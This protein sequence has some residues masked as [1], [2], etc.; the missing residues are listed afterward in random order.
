M[1]ASTI[2]KRL[3]LTRYFRTIT[4]LI[5][6]TFIN[7]CATIGTQYPERY[8]RV[9]Y[10]TNDKPIKQTIVVAL[11]KGTKT[12][13]DLKKQICYHV[14]TTVSDDNG[15]FR[16]PTWHEPLRYS[17]LADKQVYVQAFHKNYQT[18]ELTREQ[19]SHKNNIYYLAKPLNADD[20]ELA[21]Q[22]RQHY[23]LE[24]VGKAKCD[25]DGESRLNLHPMFQAI[26][27][28]ARQHVATKKD[29]QVVQKLNAWLAYVTP[30]DR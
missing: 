2:N 25:L 29:Q 20:P 23:L 5:V 17:S 11:W 27:E 18:S 12:N 28:E 7:A 14:E 22:E 24:L 4:I 10:E 15:Y 21:R 3:P 6:A 19:L 13:G 16:I 1:P 9:L 30:R 8:G 26:V